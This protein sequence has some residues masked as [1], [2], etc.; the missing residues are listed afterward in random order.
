MSIREAVFAGSWYPGS[1]GDCER[2][3]E[4]FLGARD[5]KEAD[6]H[7]ILGAIVP[8]AGWYFSG[9]IACN[10]IHRL[11]LGDPPDVLAVFGMHL[12]QGS[13]VHLMADGAWE[14]PFGPIEIEAR[15]AA[16][17]GGMFRFHIEGPRYYS[18]D[19]T[20]ELQ[21]PFIKYFLPQVKIVPVG[22]PPRAES[23]EIARSVVALADKLGM[24]LKVIGSTDLTHYGANYGFTPKGAGPAALDWVRDENDRRMVDLMLAMDPEAVIAE[25]LKHHN[26]CCSGAAAGAVEA[27]RRLG[28]RRAETLAYTTSHDKSPGSSF[29]GYVGV[30]FA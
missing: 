16:E 15:L 4:D 11:S 14:T 29:V 1:A 3:I 22:L 12:H 17:L 27:A 7:S 8:H 28:A 26:A 10:V 18:Q 20:I 19:N 24:A 21:L 6:R 2:Q 25:G 13:A 5:R 9:E 23:L 30:M